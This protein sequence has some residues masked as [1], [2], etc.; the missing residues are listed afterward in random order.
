MRSSLQQSNGLDAF[1]KFTRQHIFWKCDVSLMNTAS[2]LGPHTQ[3]DRG[4]CPGVG[5]WVNFKRRCTTRGGWWWCS[6]ANAYTQKAWHYL[7]VPSFSSTCRTFRTRCVL[8]F[9]DLARERDAS[10][11]CHSWVGYL[12]GRWLLRVLKLKNTKSRPATVLV[13]DTVTNKSEDENIIRL[14]HS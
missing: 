11:L 6:L 9:L 8:I 7:M 1:F 13:R 2:K 3:T 5:L 4:T 10:E 14:K 12:G